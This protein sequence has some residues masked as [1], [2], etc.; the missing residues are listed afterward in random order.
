MLFTKTVQSIET[1]NTFRAW[2]FLK[3]RYLVNLFL[4]KEYHRKPSHGLSLCV[5]RATLTG[6]GERRGGGGGVTSPLMYE[7]E[8]ALMMPYGKWWQR[9]RDRRALQPRSWF[10]VAAKM[11]TTSTSKVNCPEDSQGLRNR[12]PPAASFL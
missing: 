12:C 11:K 10:L 5:P 7:V 3:N 9:P 2:V 4:I 1:I 8:L 6:R